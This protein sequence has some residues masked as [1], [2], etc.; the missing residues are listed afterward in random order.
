[1][2]GEYIKRIRTERSLSQRQ[3][4]ELSGISNA[5]ISRIETGERQ[6]PSPDVLRK[7]APHLDISYE[8]LMDKAGYINDRFI[9]MAENREAEE[10]F[11]STITPKLVIDGWNIESVR[12]RDI[13]SDLVARKNNEEWHF[14]FRYFRTRDDDNKNFR[15]KSRARDVAIRSYGKLAIYS[16]TLITKF[17]LAVNDDKIFNYIKEFPPTNLNIKVTL[18]LIDLDEMKI[19]DEYEFPPTEVIK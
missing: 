14:E 16:N 12:L 13:S 19:A 7:L 4:S 9:F 8:V 6:K 11:I 2:I 3:L 5:E 17:T 1:M 18:I 15:E 10:K